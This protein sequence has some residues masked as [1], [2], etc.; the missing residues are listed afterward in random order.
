MVAS[1]VKVLIITALV[2]I[3]LLAIVVTTFIELSSRLKNSEPEPIDPTDQIGVLCVPPEPEPIT[4]APSY[5]RISQKVISTN[6]LSTNIPPYFNITH[7]VSRSAKV[8]SLKNALAT[9]H[10]LSN[11][12]Y[13]SDSLINLYPYYIKILPDRLWLSYP[14]QGTLTRNCN[15]TSCPP[16]QADLIYDAPPGNI[17]EISTLE[18]N[19]LAR[20]IVD[21]DAFTGT[22]IYQVQSSVTA[23]L[24]SL[25]FPLVK[26]SPYITIDVQNTG[27]SFLCNFPYTL[28]N[29]LDNTIYII[30]TNA[31]SGYLIY[32]SRPMTITVIDRTAYIPRF[33]GIV[34]I[35]H[36]TSQTE[37]SILNNYYNVYPLESTMSTESSTTNGISWDVDTTIN[38]TTKVM[39]ENSEQKPL[40]LLALPHHNFLSTDYLSGNYQ[41]PLIGPYRYVT[42]PNNTWI[43]AD[44]V[45]NY[46]FQYLGI[47]GQTG[48]T[49]LQNTWNNDVENLVN[50]QPDPVDLVDWMEWVGSLA[51]LTLIGKSMNYQD[52]DDI[53]NTLTS[54]LQLVGKDILG[55]VYD[56][57][58]GGLISNE[59]VNVCS[60]DT[61]SGNSFYSAHINQYGYLLLG[62]AVASYY[63]P[64][65]LQNNKSTILYF[66]RN[67]VNYYSEDP[68]FP[69][70]RN[71]DWYFGYSL[72]S[73][74]SPNQAEGKVSFN[75]AEAISGYYAAYLLSITLQN[76]ELRNWSLALLA[77]E[78]GSVQTY[79]QSNA[80]NPDF[81]NNTITERG[82]SYYEYTVSGGNPNFPERN[83]S[84]MVPML[85]PISLISFD[86]ISKQWARS[87]QSFMLDSISSPD[88]LPESLGYANSLLAVGNDPHSYA[89]TIN[90]NSNKRLPFGSTWSSMLYWILKQT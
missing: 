36:F 72:S 30:R 71:K 85:K 53:F 76:I 49:L 2:V 41:H 74:L 87:V 9:N 57:T 58:W 70:W 33:T 48:N 52:V 7:S 84:I 13:S 24:G 83:A 50:N 45:A 65:F 19:I 55:I 60:G 5:K 35:A 16:G 73:G 14:Q 54:Q 62:Y 17:I 78:I 34:R 75:P 63:N 32:L 77:S 51:I 67:T 42:T 46:E 38:W 66:L 1:S 12:F 44:A 59:G 20:D 64:T 69:L 28:E 40:L 39:N 86:A 3:I 29:Y 89:D 22:L 10:W 80:G 90:N 88:L 27:V 6:T 26:G 8:R 61:A 25:T 68:Y 81:V 47:T 15:A 18:E 56:T 4:P 82:D 37:I 23:K 31:T 21:Y 43:L 79:F 11:S